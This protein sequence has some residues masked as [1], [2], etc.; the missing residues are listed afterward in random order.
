METAFRLSREQ[1]EVAC[2]E[3]LAK[4]GVHLNGQASLNE[5][6]PFEYLSF[7]GTV[8]LGLSGEPRT[9]TAPAVEQQAAAPAVLIHASLPVPAAAPAPVERSTLAS[10]LEK[11]VPA[12]PPG[13]APKFREGNVGGGVPVGGSHQNMSAKL[14][15]LMSEPPSTVKLPP[16]VVDFRNRTP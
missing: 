7:V 12:R 9:A 5:E 10:S 1:I 15:K 14:G 4:N 13:S 8:A 11:P 6:V 2:T 16:S 3:Y